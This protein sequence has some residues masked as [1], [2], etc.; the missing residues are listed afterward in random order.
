MQSGI[1]AVINTLV[2]RSSPYWEDAEHPCPPALAAVSHRC[3]IGQAKDFERRWSKDHV[4]YLLNGR[5]CCTYLLDA[6]QEWLR[7]DSGRLEL[8]NL[9]RT[10]FKS[11]WLDRT[12]RGQIPA[13]TLGPFEFRVLEEVPEPLLDTRETTYLAANRDGY[14]GS[15]PAKRSRRWQKWDGK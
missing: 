13:W 7:A 14:V 8:L 3:Y 10:M 1:Y 11:K 2:P 15:D 12:T 6:F 9:S 4:H 5:H